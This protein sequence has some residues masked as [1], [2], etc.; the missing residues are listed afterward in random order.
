MCVVRMCVRTDVNVC[1]CV[2]EM[3]VC[4]SIYI[5]VC[6]ARMCIVC[7]TDILYECICWENLCMWM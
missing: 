1:V 2:A 5:Y 6:V 4:R 7:F 3:Y